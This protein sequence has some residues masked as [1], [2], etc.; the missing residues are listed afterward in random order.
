MSEP[1]PLRGVRASRFPRS[2]PGGTGPGGSPAASP[3]FTLIELLVVIAIIGALAALLVPAMG[4]AMEGGRAT[5]CLGNLRQIGIALQLYV[6]DSHNRMP[7]MR[8]RSLETNAPATD[9]LPSPDVLL[10]H[11]LGSTNVLRCLSDRK[12]LFEQTGSS[13][14]WNSLLNGQDAEHLTVMAIPFDPHQIPLMFDK[15]AFHKARGEKKGVNYLYADGHIKNLLV[16][17]G[18]R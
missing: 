7:V 1:A 11:H 8:D 13:Y 10:A 14:A 6:Q 5:S 17:E 2:A 4:R 12:R 9:G 18:A 16:L 15:E 3:S